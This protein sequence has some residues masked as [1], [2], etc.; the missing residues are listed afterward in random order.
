[1]ENFDELALT[2]DKEPH[3]IERA[4][5]VADAIRKNIP[6][7]NQK[8]GFEYGCGT[9]LLSFNL[10]HDL[11]TITLAD[12]STGMLAVLAQKIQDQAIANLK[13]LQLDLTTDPAPPLSYDI[14]Y[15]LMT[16]H[17]IVEI[18]PVLQK[19][20]TMSNS[21]GYLC[22]AD[23]DA[24]DGSFHGKDFVG[25]NGFNQER[26]ASMLKRS[27]FSFL[28]SE[29]CYEVVKR[30]ETGATKKYPVFIMFGQKG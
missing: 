24:E 29:I 2:W 21:G 7:L 12:S 30:T 15:T 17:H 18:E 19:F 23:L 27:G 8:T 14:I 25:H 9:G 11:K 16:M 20:H 13:L 3:R 22:I 6:N 26:L 1:M 10:H 4:K 5:A 28:G